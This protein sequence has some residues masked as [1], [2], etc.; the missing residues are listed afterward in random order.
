MPIYGSRAQ[1]NIARLGRASDN[2]IIWLL[3]LTMLDTTVSADPFSQRLARIRQQIAQGQLREAAL[4][5]NQAQ[6]EAPA[7]ARVPLVGMRLAD[8]A[9]NL[10]GAIQAAR[11]ALTLAPGWAV[12]QA[13]LAQLLVRTGGAGETQEA[14]ELARQARAADLDHVQLAVGA[15]NVALA[16]HDDALAL[17]WAEEALEHHPSYA[18][19]HL[20]AGQLLAAQGRAAQALPHLR[21]AHDLNPVQILPLLAL[22]Q[23]ASALGDAAAAQ[24]WADRALALAPDDEAVRY[25]NAVAHGE[26]PATQPAAVVR[27]LFDHYPADYDRHMAGTLHYRAPERIAALLREKFPDLR[28]NLLDLGCGTGFVGACLGRIEGYM[29]GVDLSQVMIDQ[30]ERRGVYARFHLVNLLDALAGTPGDVYEAITCA[31]ALPYVGDLTPVLP[32]A[33]RVLKPGGWLLLTGEAAQ[34]DEGDPAAGYVLRASNRYAH[35][36]EAVERQLR[37]AGFAPVTLEALPELRLEGGAPLA[38]FL[39]VAQKP[40]AA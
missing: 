29:I 39:A 35:R 13:E 1:P 7:D 38:G 28:F 32:N 14:V 22:L 3:P 31:D 11:R 4:A 37:A 9:G 20:F 17:Q 25:W 33:L 19:L 34:A 26:T 36:V 12:A 16:A 5:L 18:D 6:Q 15:V 30:A 24:T 40:T 10:K 23:T 27:A 8:A 21:Q 2:Q